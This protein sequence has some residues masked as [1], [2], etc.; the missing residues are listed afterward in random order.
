MPS[1]VGGE[2]PSPRQEKFGGSGGLLGASGIRREAE[3]NSDGGGK[4]SGAV[5]LCL[6]TKRGTVPAS[7]V[8]QWPVSGEGPR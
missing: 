6:R 8:P 3:V 4:G 1:P 7:S 2:A 5:P